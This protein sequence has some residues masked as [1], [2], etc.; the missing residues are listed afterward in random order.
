MHGV[1]AEAQLDE[2]AGH[3][4]DHRIRPADPGLIDAVATAEPLVQLGNLIGVQSAARDLE[5]LLFLAEDEVQLQAL[6]KTVFQCEQ[7]VDEHRRVLFAVTVK[8][9]EAAVRLLLED[10]RCNRQDRRDAATRR[11]TNMKL[12]VRPFRRE[13][14][15][16]RRRHDRQRVPDRK[17]VRRELAERAAR[18]YAHPDLQRPAAGRRADAVGPAQLL[19][20]P[21]DLDRQV[22]AR[23]ERVLLAKFLGHVERDT[24]GVFGFRGLRSDGQ[25]VKL[26]HRH[27]KYSKGSRQ[28]QHRYDALQAV[29]PNSLTRSVF[30]DV[31]RGQTTGP[32]RRWGGAI[33]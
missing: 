11:K 23:Q 17:L 18:L 3:G 5:L 21:F 10:R 15:A 26:F 7:V 28:S 8:Q 22:L 32:S 33:P 19:A 30:S 25:V 9:C 12:A 1:F 14:K 4:V 16:S 31:Q 13:M 29:E 2:R 6:G 24:E 27:L 20:V